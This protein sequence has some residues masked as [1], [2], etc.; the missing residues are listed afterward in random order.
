M[1]TR[2][3]LIAKALGQ[4]IKIQAELAKL[5]EGCLHNEGYFIGY[6]SYRVGAVEIS[7]ICDTCQMAIEGITSDEINQ[8]VK[9]KK[10]A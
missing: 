2:K 8:F 5:R 9:D 3:E 10:D 7:R 6:W 1:M 4:S